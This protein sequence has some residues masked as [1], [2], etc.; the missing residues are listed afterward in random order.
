MEQPDAR[1]TTDHDVTGVV[2]VLAWL[3]ALAAA[4]TWGGLVLARKRRH[5]RRPPGRQAAP[6]EPGAVRTEKALREQAAVLDTKW[7]DV[8]LHSMANSLID[9]QGNYPDITAA[10]LS[11]D[12]LRLQLTSPMQAPPP[13]LTFESEWVLPAT[14]ELPLASARAADQ[15]A[16]LPALASIGTRGQETVLLDLERAGTVT[17][18][19]PAAACRELLTHLVLELAHNTWSDGLT[20]TLVGWGED[21]VVL[22][23]DRLVHATSMTAVVREMHARLA[24]AETSMGALDTDVLTGRINDIAGDSWMP[25][26]LLIDGTSCTPGQL[27]AL[28]DAVTAVTRTDRNTT[29][30]VL[31]GAHHLPTTMELI[32]DDGGSLRIPALLGDQPIVAARVHEDEAR[33][34]CSLFTVADRMDTPAPPATAQAPWAAGMND[35]GALLDPAPVS[36]GHNTAD[37]GDPD[38]DQ[39][40]QESSQPAVVVQMRPVSTAASTQQA[41]VLA[42]DQHLDADLAEWHSEETLRPQISLLGHPTSPPPARNPRIARRG[43][44]R[45]PST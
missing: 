28:D 11:A 23:P 45:W 35:S 5:R 42:A 41:N 16:P 30:V 20:V 25:Q 33:E 6:T 40:G 9:G 4:A 18:T 26:V 24:E 22:N 13:F 32:L 14:V 8:A 29:A 38:H 44:P 37:N 17:V 2:S 27:E 3:S 21:L 12:Q 15:L 43:S 7:L 39:T 34:L 36:L 31:T 1:S 19:G 10:Y